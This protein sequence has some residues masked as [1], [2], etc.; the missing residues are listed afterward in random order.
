[1]NRTKI[2][3]NRSRVRRYRAAHRRIDYVPSPDVQR[4]IEHHLTWNGSLDGWRD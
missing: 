3:A 2:T 1:M 4:I